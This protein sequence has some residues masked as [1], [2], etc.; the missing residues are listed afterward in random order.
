MPA[1][2]VGPCIRLMPAAVMALVGSKAA[3]RSY[4]HH[5]RGDA[6]LRRR[7][8][9]LLLRQDL[10]RWHHPRPG[11]QA[12]RRVVRRRSPCSWPASCSLLTRAL[13]TSA[14]CPCPF[15]LPL[16]LLLLLLLLPAHAPPNLLPP[17]P[18][19]QL[20]PPHT[21]HTH[22]S[23]FSILLRSRLAAACSPLC[24]HR[25]VP[26]PHVL[27]GPAGQSIS[28]SATSASPRSSSG[29]ASS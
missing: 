7:L 9:R 29:S 22:P 5:L 20:L 10:H 23:P 3:A 24:A 28:R 19:C 16:L 12:H 8:P 17:A 13:A 6:A 4:D 2:M 26:A 18:P 21:P 11:Q 14:T 25:T 1:A 15:N 27:P